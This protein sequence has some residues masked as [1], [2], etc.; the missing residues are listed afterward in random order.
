MALCPRLTTPALAAF[1]LLHT[2]ATA[3]TVLGAAR[4]LSTDAVPRVLEEVGEVNSFLQVGTVV[5][6]GKG[7]SLPAQTRAH[8]A[9]RMDNGAAAALARKVVQKTTHSLNKDS[10]LLQSTAH[11]K[12]DAVSYDS[13]GFRRICF[14]ITIVLSV[15]MVLGLF[16]VCVEVRWR[17]FS[18]AEDAPEGG[19]QPLQ[20]KPALEREHAQMSSNSSPGS[21]LARSNPVPRKDSFSPASTAN[22]KRY[23]IGDQVPKYG[24]QRPSTDSLGIPARPS[25]DSSGLPPTPHFSERLVRAESNASGEEITLFAKDG[26]PVNARA[27]PMQRHSPRSMWWKSP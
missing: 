20:H 13:I 24:E 16:V 2:V 9:V 23:Y 15:I 27:S 12:R 3:A 5:H 19:S 11:A 22:T 25:L 21:A 26:S 7:S 8:A 1:V 14:I 4:R 10:S 18:R 17:G 6:V